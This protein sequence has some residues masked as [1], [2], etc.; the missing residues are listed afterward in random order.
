MIIVNIFVIAFV[1]YCAFNLG[2][3][4]LWIELWQKE[5]EAAPPPLSQQK[6]IYAHNQLLLDSVHK[7]I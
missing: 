5:N 6:Q 2:K 3:F 1:I 7:G 4:L